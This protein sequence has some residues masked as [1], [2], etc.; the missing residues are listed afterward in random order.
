MD[1]VADQGIRNMNNESNPNVRFSEKSSG[2]DQQPVTRST[3]IGAEDKPQYKFAGQSQTIKKTL[4]H[5]Q[6][7]SNQVSQQVSQKD[8]RKNSEIYTAI[9][10][11]KTYESDAT[12]GVRSTQKSNFIQQ[13]KHCIATPTLG[14]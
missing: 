2:G 5:F 11:P 6:I 12:P 9:P 7:F 3:K 13:K 14:Q 4:P 8:T 1:W 10:T